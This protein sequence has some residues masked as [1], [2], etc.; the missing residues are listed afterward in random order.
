MSY[1]PA[2]SSSPSPFS[3]GARLSRTDVCI[4]EALIHLCRLRD[5]NSARGTEWPKSWFSNMKGKANELL[6]CTELES[7][8][9]AVLADGAREGGSTSFQLKS[10]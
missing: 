1:C 3:D 7:L 8:M 5:S 10:V 9:V 4:T 6:N 2:P